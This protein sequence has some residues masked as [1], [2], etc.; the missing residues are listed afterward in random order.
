M[1]W[2]SPRFRMPGIEYLYKM[3]AKPVENK[4]EVEVLMNASRSNDEFC[5]MLGMHLQNVE[6][7]SGTDPFDLAEGYKF[8][9]MEYFR[10]INI[11]ENQKYIAANCLEINVSHR[12]IAKLF[13]MPLETIED[14]ASSTVYWQHQMIYL[15]TTTNRALLERQLSAIRYMLLN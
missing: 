5:S 10:R 13:Q 14:F 7:W 8:I 2:S 3:E 4:T 1:N 15:L 9:L 6:E 12:D 11:E